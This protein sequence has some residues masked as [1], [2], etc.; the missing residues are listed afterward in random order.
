MH[1]QGDKLGT[2]FFLCSNNHTK[3][4]ILTGCYWGLAVQADVW[5]CKSSILA[6]SIPM[7][8]NNCQ[9]VTY[10]IILAYCGLKERR[11]WC[12]SPL[13]IISHTI[14]NCMYKNAMIKQGIIMWIATI[15]STKISSFR[16]SQYTFFSN[17]CNST[18]IISQGLRW[19]WLQSLWWCWGVWTVPWWLPPARTSLFHPLLILPPETS[20]LPPLQNCFW[21]WQG[22]THHGSLS[23]I[24]RCQ[25]VHAVYNRKAIDEI[26]SIGLVPHS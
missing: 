3:G 24:V 4:N 20:L 6:R 22:S 18:E 21:M 2:V 19:W 16:K 7:S 9:L 11:W 23:Q 15:L 12:R 17:L 26:Y 10:T 8:R 13:C 5:T 1:V 25:D 14:C